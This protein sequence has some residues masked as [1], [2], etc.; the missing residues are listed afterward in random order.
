MFCS[1][2]PPEFSTTFFPNCQLQLINCD[3]FEIVTFVGPGRT[4][5]YMLHLWT[6]PVILLESGAGAMGRRGELYKFELEKLVYFLFGW[7]L[8]RRFEL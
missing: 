2:C 3:Q 6:H 1:V 5:A 8:S 7:R 4:T